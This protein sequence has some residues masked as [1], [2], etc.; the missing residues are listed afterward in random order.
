MGQARSFE[1][2]NVKVAHILSFHSE[3]QNVVTLSCKED[4]KTQS[5]FG[6]LMPLLQCLITTENEGKVAH[7]RPQLLPHAP[8]S[9]QEPACWGG[10]GEAEARLCLDGGPQKGVS[11]SSEPENVTLFGKR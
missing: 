11:T 4:G 10:A 3:G 2:S 1:R 9:Y 7:E 8:E 6:R 5:S